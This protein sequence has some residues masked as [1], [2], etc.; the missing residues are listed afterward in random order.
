MLR[1]KFQP[2]SRG[3]HAELSLDYLR[4]GSKIGKQ[5]P[6]NVG[7]VVVV[8]LRMLD[9]WDCVAVLAVGCVLCTA[10]PM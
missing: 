8:R 5:R 4:F 7:A 3:R 6:E 9:V 10:V 2:H 1:T